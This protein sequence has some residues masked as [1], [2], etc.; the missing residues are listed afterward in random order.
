MVPVKSAL[1]LFAA[2]LLVSCGSASGD[3]TS[4]T[5][6]TTTGAPVATTLAPADEPLEIE[7]TVGEDS[8]PDRI[9]LV[10]LGTNVRITLTNPGI[11]DEYHLHGY[12]IVTKKMAPGM[13]ATI[14]FSADEPGTFELESHVTNEVLVVLE[15]Q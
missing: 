10:E 8:G 1:P 14:S 4:T 9:E 3:A 11:E 15:I 2:L 13:P 5:T 6:S 12:D 7:V